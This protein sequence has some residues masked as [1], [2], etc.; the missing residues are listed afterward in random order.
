MLKPNSKLLAHFDTLAYLFSKL[1]S[2]PG[3]LSQNFFYAQ[4]NLKGFFVSRCL[5]FKVRLLLTRLENLSS[6]RECLTIISRS[7]SFVNDFFKKIQRFHNPPGCFAFFLSDEPNPI[8]PNR[9]A[10]RQRDRIISL[11]YG[12][13]NTEI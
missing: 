8:I 2:K 6:T 1:L 12:N 3:L 9:F 5:I 11:Q 7:I 4:K 10:R 13:V